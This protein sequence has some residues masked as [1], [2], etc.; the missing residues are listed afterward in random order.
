MRSASKRGNRI[1]GYLHLII[2]YL[3]VCLLVWATWLSTLESRRTPQSSFEGDSEESTSRQFLEQD[4]I[5]EV[6]CG[7]SRIFMLSSTSLQDGP[8]GPYRRE[9][10]RE[11]M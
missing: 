3:E 5:L 1:V 6:A 2:G 9:R 7:T 11:R 8:M 10:D 4:A